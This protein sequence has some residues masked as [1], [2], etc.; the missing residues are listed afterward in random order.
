[1][2]S[3]GP[4]SKFSGRLIVIEPT[5]RWQ[6]LVNWDGTP[7]RGLIRLT[8]AASNRI[9]QLSWHDDIT[10]IL[11]NRDPAGEWKAVTKEEIIKQGVILPPQQLAL[12]LSGKLPK[13]FIQKKPGRWQ[14]KINKTFLKI[15]WSAE[16]HKLELMD[17]THGRQAILIIQP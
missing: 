7:E 8:H 14:G 6:V 10:H 15:K 5:R 1:M 12:I 2:A 11:D 17:I 4:Y 9:I 16:K 13:S 3:I